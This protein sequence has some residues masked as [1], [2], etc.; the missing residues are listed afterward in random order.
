[1]KPTKKEIVEFLVK[2]VPGLVM[3]KISYIKEHDYSLCFITTKK[4]RFGKD[5]PEAKYYQSYRFDGVNFKQHN[6]P[7]NI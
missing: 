7:S 6:P 2:K 4:D 3:A 1:M 5:C